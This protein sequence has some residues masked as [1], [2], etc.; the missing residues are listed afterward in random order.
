MDTIILSHWQNADSNFK[1]DTSSSLQFNRPNC[2]H[3]AFQA[4]SCN[5]SVWLVR[6]R[7]YRPV[8]MKNGTRNFPARIRLRRICSVLPSNGKVPQTSTYRTMPRLCIQQAYN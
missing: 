4:P 1:C 3:T 2:M 8:D 7:K 6:C 5:P